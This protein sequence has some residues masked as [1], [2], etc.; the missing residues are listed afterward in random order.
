LLLYLPIFTPPLS[1]KC[2]FIPLI[3]IFI[4]SQ[5]LLSYALLGNLLNSNAYKLQSQ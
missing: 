2:F 5:K 3:P 1:R 4:L